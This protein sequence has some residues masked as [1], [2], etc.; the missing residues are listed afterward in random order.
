M[1]WH[2]ARCVAVVV[3][4]LA[5]APV[6]AAAVQDPPAP[7]APQ[8]PPAEEPPVSPPA[9][10]EPQ[11]QEDTLTAADEAPG[12]RDVT[13]SFAGNFIADRLPFD[14]PFNVTGS[15]E[16]SVKR[17]ELSVYRVPSNVDLAELIN[18]LQTTVDCVGRRPQGPRVVRVSRSVA[19]P[20]AGGRFSLFV[21]AL[22]PQYF[23]ALCFVGVTPVPSAE[24][25]ADARRVLAA[26]IPR[27]D[28]GGDIRLTLLAD[29]RAA[30][31]DRIAQLGAGR[32]V[33]ARIPEGNLFDRSREHPQFGPIVARL[34]EP[35]GNMA[36][37]A[38]GFNESLEAL[39]ADVAAARAAKVAI[40]SELLAALPPATLRLPSR[41]S[42]VT[43]NRPFDAAAYT[44]AT[45][46][47]LLDKALGSDAADSQ[48]SARDAL[49]DS[50]LELEDAAKTYGGFY[51]SLRNVTNELLTFV[52]LEAQAVTV[53]LGSSVLGADLVRSAY[54]SLDAGIAYPWRLENMVFYAGSNI[55]FR[56][57]N[58]AAPL[59]YKGTFLHRFALTVGV[60]TTV[61][62]DSRRAQDLR[63][64]DQEDTSNSLLLG[65]G[66]RITPSLRV[67]GG[68]LVF[69]ESDPNPLIEQTS[70][71]VTPYVAFTADVNVAQIF[72][73][74]F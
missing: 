27:T 61:N 21:N 32:R 37:Q 35:Y 47:Q 40:T 57:I 20:G 36:I 70:V 68:V 7:A 62:D 3:L 13:V 12:S 10:K 23:Y 45:A 64:T 55:Y 52:A 6:A 17:L 26:T 43:A 60:T 8:E 44:F 14:V 48:R 51:E 65:A 53:T 50:I 42:A 22:D 56:P 54:I 19:T 24:I 49:V 25:D 30:M 66:I 59:R 71:A 73:S 38:R 29:I 72:R 34:A 58:K 33:P 46:K 18:Y 31:S 2:R 16:A 74:M 5:S 1:P 67:G 69:K 11:P 15:V 4:V 9:L 28:T 41:E 63:A 39:V